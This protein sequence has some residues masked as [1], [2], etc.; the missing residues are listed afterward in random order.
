MSFSDPPVIF[1]ECKGSELAA[2]YTQRARE[3]FKRATAIEESIARMPS[4][5]L[6]ARGP[7]Q[8]ELDE[9]GLELEELGLYAPMVPPPPHDPHSGHARAEQQWKR[10][11]RQALEAVKRE[12]EFYTFCAEHLDAE[13]VYRVFAREVR[14]LFGGDRFG[15]FGHQHVIGAPPP[16]PFY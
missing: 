3:S 7:E 9:V 10:Y 4:K 16:L 8:E 6:R 14:E 11:A 12:G 2:L 15:S 5:P 13:H 1:L